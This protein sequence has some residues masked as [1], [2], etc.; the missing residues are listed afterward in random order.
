ML[1]KNLVILKHPLVEDYMTRIRDKRTSYLDF[2]IFVDKLSFMLAYESAKNLSLK[3]RNV[4][5]PLTGFSGK[6]VKDNI[7]LVPI[8][9]AGLG[10]LRGFT[11]VFP[12]AKVSHIGIYRNEETLVPVK[13]YF[14]FPRL[15]SKT[16]TIVYVLDPMLATGGSIDC[17]VSEI[18]KIGIRK[19]IVSSLVSAP[20]GIKEI[21]TKHRNVKIYTCAL[22]KKLN[23]KGYIVPGLDDAGDRMFGT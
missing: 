1:N 15:A 11:E 14:K 3:S 4:K 22:D 12:S 16:N 17:A 2:R 10:L 21:N 18:K 9:R 20:E 8:L 5:T 13:Y 19:I 7:V 6:E 23:E